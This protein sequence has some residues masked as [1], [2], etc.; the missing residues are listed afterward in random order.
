MG[1]GTQGQ[2]QAH[3]MGG[4]DGGLGGTAEGGGGDGGL[5]EGGSEVT[6]HHHVHHHHHHPSPNMHVRSNIRLDEADLN[7]A[8]EAVRR[9]KQQQREREH[10]QRGL[11]YDWR[12]SGQEQG[13]GQ[14]QRGYGGRGEGAGRGRT[15]SE[16]S[17]GEVSHLGAT[18][19][20]PSRLDS[21]LTPP[22]ATSRL[23]NECLT[24]PPTRNYQLTSSPAHQLTNRPTDESITRAGSMTR[25]TSI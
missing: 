3:G 14:G 19:T 10:D 11:A 8:S 1:A 22:T 7:Q 23:P 6:H 20:S 25:S 9:Q 12:Q 16:D 24:S 18:S 17:F 13:A 4:G 15:G 21:A 5:A 2:G